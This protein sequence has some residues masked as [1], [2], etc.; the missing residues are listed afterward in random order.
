MKK[1]STYKNVAIGFIGIVICLFI[2]SLCSCTKWEE[3]VTQVSNVTELTLNDTTT[4]NVDLGGV[5]VNPADV[6][7]NEGSTIIN[8]GNTTVNIAPPALTFNYAFETI[9]NSVDSSKV[10]V[11]VAGSSLQTGDIVIS[12]INTNENT[13]TNTNTN[14]IDANAN[15][16]NINTLTNGVTVNTDNTLTIESNV[17]Q[18]SCPYVPDKCIIR[19]CKFHKCKE[20]YKNH[21]GGC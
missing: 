19:N 13:G 5:T 18:E 14:D 16:S 15:A 4:V 2:A 11:D 17:E 9:N 20:Y 3:S 8:E 10:I 12:A 7:I 6:T 1:E 21:K